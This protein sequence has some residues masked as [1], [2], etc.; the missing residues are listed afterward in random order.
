LSEEAKKCEGNP[1]PYGGGKWAGHLWNQYL[2]MAQ[3]ARHEGS[4]PFHAQE[5]VLRAL[6][7]KKKWRDLSMSC[8]SSSQNYLGLHVRMEPDMIGHACGKT[9]EHNATRL[10]HH[11]THFLSLHNGNHSNISIDTISI[12]TSRKDMEIKTGRR[13][14]QF[15]TIM[16]ENLSTL[17]HYTKSNEIHIWG[18]RQ[19][20]IFECGEELVKQYLKQHPE[21]NAIN[22]GSVLPMMINF[23]MLTEA[24]IFIGVRKSSYSTD[25]WTTRYYQ[26]K[27]KYNYEYTPE[28]ILP[29]ENDG[30]PLVHTAC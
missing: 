23:H 5:F 30:L 9:M 4:F 11:I 1:I 16:D 3:R 6:I 22:Y 25:V 8:V 13:Y 29:I 10:F 15:K 14:H 26:G 2:R 21:E 24:K 19:V 28:G 7:P 20:S 17:N 27:G 18:G 12:A